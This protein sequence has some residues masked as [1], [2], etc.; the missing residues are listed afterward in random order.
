M[1]VSRKVHRM[2]VEFVMVTPAQVEFA[3]R[4][5]SE[6]RFYTR[7]L[8]SSALYPS[9]FPWPAWRHLRLIRAILRSRAR[10]LTIGEGLSMS[11]CTPLY[12]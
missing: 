4:Q 8:V 7:N 2:K 11:S 10:T 1:S 12:D 6:V 9:A 5:R 3:S